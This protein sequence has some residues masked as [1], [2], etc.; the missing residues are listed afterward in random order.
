MISK[1]YVALLDEG[2]DVWRPVAAEALGSGLFRIVGAVPDGEVWEYQPSEIVNVR[3][4]TF[5]DGS[6]GL[7]ATKLGAA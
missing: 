7:V 2:S 1:I 6:K 3:E 5:S 4:Y